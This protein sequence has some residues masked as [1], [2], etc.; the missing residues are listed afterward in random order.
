MCQNVRILV[1]IR[2]KAITFVQI[3]RTSDI[4]KISREGAIKL[5]SRSCLSIPDFS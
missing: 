2:Q 4:L 5:S 3:S 1:A